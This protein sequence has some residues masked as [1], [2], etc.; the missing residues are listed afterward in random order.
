MKKLICAAGRLILRFLFRVEVRGM[1]NY[2]AAGPRA[3]IMPNHV[4]LLDPALA[5][6]FIPD[7]PVFAINSLV[8][9]WRWVRPFLALFRT[10]SVDPTNPFGLKGLIEE[11]KRDQHCVI[12]PEGR[13]TT[14][15]SQMRAFDGAAMLADK[16][17]AVLLPLR[18]EGAQLSRAS[19]L[20]GRFPVRWFPKITLTF[21]PPRRLEIPP[22]VKGRRRRAMAQTFLQDL[23][24]DAA[25]QV[26]DSGRTLFG[27]LL[28]ARRL[29][30][31]RRVI[32]A[33][34]GR[35]PVTYDGMVRAALVLG[36]LFGGR[37]NPGE[38]AGLLMPS[39]VPTAALAL[40]LSRLGHTPAMLNC[41]VGAQNALAC[42]RAAEIRTVISSRRFVEAGKLGALVEAMESAG[43]RFLW[44]ED[45]ARALGLRAKLTAWFQARFTTPETAGGPD[46]EAVVLFTSG[47]EGTPKGVALSHRNIV[48]NRDQL[49]SSV[50]FRP[51]DVVLNAM[52]MFHVFGFVVGTI[53]P[54]L[55][56]MYTFYFPSPL[57]YRAIPLV[58]YDINAT[59]LFGTDTFLYG[60]ARSASPYDFYSV[61]YVFEGAEKLRERTSRM[62]SEKFGIR[63][64]EGYGTTE[65]SVV[66]LNTALQ[67]SAG[68][69]GR[70]LPGLETRLEPVVGLEGV[71]RLFL[72]GPNVMMGYLRSERPGVLQPVED[73]WYDT[74]D[75]V[76]L[77]EL[78]FLSIRGRAKR[79][80][81]IGG[82]MVS[83]TALE[84]EME[85][86]W[87]GVRCA[88][89]VVRDERKGERIILV[90]EKKDASR[91][92]MTAH[93]K[94]AGYAEVA[95]PKKLL[96][97]GKLPLL[98]SGKTDYP[99]L[100]RLASETAGAAE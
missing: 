57:S 59:V 33:D 71:G 82:E 31:R 3:V 35:K 46:D 55:S 56:G 7:E 26:R 62:W 68:T 100:D 85:R 93:L 83:L 63:V 14:T 60:Y 29:Y 4:S 48:A 87:P 16:T 15:G 65:T 89:A 73:G 27:A 80:A 88:M 9:R 5:A 69:V 11:L 25:W 77:D 41:T 51:S 18:I 66:S 54:L 67:C 92:E 32:A 53:M 34:I 12:F 96:P 98:G 99:A 45:E 1:E 38:R 2:R 40:G 84:E 37:F 91:E 72:R 79:F 43:L 13:I 58:A 28:D 8:A 74:G 78:G 64:L 30:G 6:L 61:R 86:L 24:R 10:W 22:E 20:R 94:A 52:P 75:I 17:G 42:C 19:Y 76:R 44:L 49:M 23:L 81:K 70:V 36:N 47:S 97:V 90:T 95:I 50:D 21:L 39:S